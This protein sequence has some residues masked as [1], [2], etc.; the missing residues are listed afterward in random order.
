MCKVQKNF[1]E[2]CTS[3]KPFLL[4]CYEWKEALQCFI[5]SAQGQI[6]IILTDLLFDYCKEG[7]RFLTQ[8][9]V[10]LFCLVF[11][12]ANRNR[13]FNK[14]THNICRIHYLM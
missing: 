8:F 14:V 7:L 1:A 9:L 12:I 11:P 13:E 2:C 3:V 4:L 10:F 6:H 5:C